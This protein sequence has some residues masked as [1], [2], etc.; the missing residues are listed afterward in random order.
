MAAEWRSVVLTV[1]TTTP[2]SGYL[3]LPKGAPLPE[4]GHALVRA[5]SAPEKIQLLKLGRRSDTGTAAWVDADTAE[6]LGG[7][8][9]EVEYR[10]AGWILVLRYNSDAR[11][12]LA[13][14]VLTALSAVLVGYGTFLTSHAPGTPTFVARAAFAVLLITTGLAVLQLIKDIKDATS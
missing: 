1:R 7:D 2:R 5:K 12:Q 13:I 8:G 10:P 9:A 6:A 4:T 3:L 11:V 14:S